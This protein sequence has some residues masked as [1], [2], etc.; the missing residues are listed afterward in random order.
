MHLCVCVC[1]GE[2]ELERELER[3]RE[4]KREI[5]LREEGG[6]VGSEPN[7]KWNIS[8]SSASYS[9]VIK[10]CHLNF[11]TPSFWIHS[12]PLSSAIWDMFSVEPFSQI[13]LE[14]WSSWIVHRDQKAAFASTCDLRYIC[15]IV[16][17]ASLQP[18][19]VKV[20]RHYS[21]DNSIVTV[22]ISS[23]GKALRTVLFVWHIST[24]EL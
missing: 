3:E 15:T 2:R 12:H 7:Q 5:L 1:F 14:W 19:I 11:K 8:L 24:V 6:W 21:F 23:A 22:M 18:V 13:S 10:N 9:C 17:I 20:L 4:R 16:V